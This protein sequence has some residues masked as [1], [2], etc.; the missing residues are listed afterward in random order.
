LRSPSKFMQVLF[1]GKVF[2]QKFSLHAG[3]CS[4]N[5]PCEDGRSP[6]HCAVAEVDTCAPIAVRLLLPGDLI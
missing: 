6:L 2:W 4:V 1:L 3:R 5:S